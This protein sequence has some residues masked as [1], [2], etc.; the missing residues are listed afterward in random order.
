MPN[1]NLTGAE[2]A[3]LFA[4]LLT[5]VRSRLLTLAG[6]DPE[7][8]W[9]LRRKLAKELSY[10]ER[11]KPVQRRA[12][13]ARK[14]KAQGGLCTECRSPLPESGA[15]LDRFEAMDGY[16]DANT[17]LICPACDVKIQADKRYT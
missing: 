17:R 13:K 2:L 6:G 8:H 3:G 4:P 1:R 5:N 7:L 16:T 14:R 10:D 9:A 11:S 12:L 15:V